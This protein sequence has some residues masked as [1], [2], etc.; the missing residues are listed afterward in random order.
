METSLAT[1][2]F[3]LDSFFSDF[4]LRLGHVSISFGTQNHIFLITMCSDII[5]WENFK[6]ILIQTQKNESNKHHTISAWPTTLDIQLSLT[7]TSI[8]SLTHSS[9][10]LLIY[11]GYKGDGNYNT[12]I[13]DKAM[14]E[15]FSN[16]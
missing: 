4:Q 14:V 16:P 8:A 10:P 5:C 13:E 9:Y 12:D 6:E 3:T 7:T 1:L 15:S 2:I 11:K